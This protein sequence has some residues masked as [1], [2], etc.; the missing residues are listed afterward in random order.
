VPSQPEDIGETTITLTTDE[1]RGERPFYARLG[2][3]VLLAAL[4]YLVWRIVAPLW[5]PLA[6]ALLL[7]SLL[8]PL[9]LRLAHRLGGRTRLA[10]SLTLLATVLLFILP[11]ATVAG[12]VTTQAAQLL[13]KLELNMS[14][15]SRGLSLD[16]AHVPWLERP[17]AWID[18]NTSVSLAQLQGWL[19][20]VADSEEGGL[21]AD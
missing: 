11:V 2:A 1:S 13:R 14:E 17:L 3:V 4:G 16:L 6:W 20:E 12:A 10:S 7:G 21:P 9:N 8:A 15:V 18:A 5:Q 19:V